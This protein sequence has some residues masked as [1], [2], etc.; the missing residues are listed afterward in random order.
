MVQGSYVRLRTRSLFLSISL[1]FFFPYER[2]EVGGFALCA[3]IPFLFF[4]LLAFLFFFPYERIEVGG[5]ALRA[6]IPFLFFYSSSPMRASIRVP[7]VLL[8]VG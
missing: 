2:I 1:L 5:F 3:S 7:W 4:P 8:P 6:S